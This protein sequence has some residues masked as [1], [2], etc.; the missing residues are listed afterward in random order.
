MSSDGLWL[1]W[2]DVD[3]K[4]MEYLSRIV[5]SQLYIG[6]PVYFFFNLAS[7]NLTDKSQLV[8]L[9]AIV[10]LSRQWHLKV[11]VTGAADSVTGTAD[12]NFALSQ[13]RADYISSILQERGVPSEMIQTVA[14]GGIEQFNPV[15]LSRQCK[16]EIIL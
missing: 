6:S 13:A 4:S 7:T 10:E 9:D 5:K 1:R 11:R 2:D 15:A 3:E 8:N 12:S 16:V 14:I